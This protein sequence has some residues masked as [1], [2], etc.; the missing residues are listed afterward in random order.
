M[1]DLGTLPGDDFSVAEGMNDESQVV[2]VSCGPSNN[3]RAFVWQNGSMT[4]LNQLIP[5]HSRLYLIRGEDIN[6]SGQIVGDAVDAKGRQRA[7][8]LIPSGKAGVVPNA[9]S[10]RK[11]ILPNTLRM[12]LRASGVFGPFLPGL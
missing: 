5:P 8:T 4:D 7:V 6:D 10:A 1:S 2:G 11:V 12:P 3:C 9:T